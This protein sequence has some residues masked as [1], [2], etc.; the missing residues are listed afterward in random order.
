MLSDSA[1]ADGQIVWLANCNLQMHINPSLIFSL[2]WP[3]PPP[4]G[5]HRRGLHR[6]VDTKLV[7]CVDDPTSPLSYHI[8]HW[9]NSLAEVCSHHSLSPN[10]TMPTPPWSPRQTRDVPFSPNSI[11]PTSP[12]LL[13]LRK[14]RESRRNGIWALL[15]YLQHDAMMATLFA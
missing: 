13:R 6:Y 7:K 1:A 5:V 11:T 14:F 4:S 2:I 9:S 12:K 8:H 3:P 15:V 10:C